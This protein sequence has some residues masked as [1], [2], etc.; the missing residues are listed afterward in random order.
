MMLEWIGFMFDK[1]ISAV[2]EISNNDMEMN[3]DS[4]TETQV[5]RGCIENADSLKTPLDR[6]RLQKFKIKVCRHR[7]I[8]Y[9]KNREEHP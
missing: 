2:Q 9:P 6:F 8:F 5:K 1:C 4:A 7:G 3:S